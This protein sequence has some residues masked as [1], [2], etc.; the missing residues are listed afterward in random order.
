MELYGEI[1]EIKNLIRKAE[2][3]AELLYR[4]NHYMGFISLKKFFDE[5]MKNYNMLIKVSEKLQIQEG[6]IQEICQLFMQ[7]QKQEDAI[8]L[9]DL[10][11]SQWIPW[12]YQIQEYILT[13][14]VSIENVGDQSYEEEIY[15]N[16]KERLSN[17]RPLLWEKLQ[18]ELLSEE[19]VYSY[20]VEP[21]SIGSPTIAVCMGEERFYL[22][23]NKNPYKEAELWA[24]EYY[25]KKVSSYV[26]FGFAFGYHIEALLEKSKNIHIKVLEFDSKLLDVALHHREL[27]SILCDDRVEMIL[28][29]N[30]SVLMKHI[31]SNGEYFFIHAPSLRRLPKSVYK[32]ML[33]EYFMNISTMKSQGKLLD[34]NFYWN[35]RS[36]EQVQNVD[37]LRGKFEKQSVILVAGGP[38]LDHT[39]EWLREHKEKY[40]V[41]AVGT[42]IKKL[43]NRHI[44]PDYVIITDPQERTY[45]QIADVDLKDIPLLYMSTVNDKI[46]QRYTGAKYMILQKGYEPAEELA[47]KYHY[48]MYETGGSVSTTAID[49]CIRLGCAKLVCLGLDLA[50]T[51]HKT[52]ASDT[53]DAAD[54]QREGLEQVKSVKGEWIETAKNFNVYRHW[55][56]RRIRNIENVKIVNISNGAC[57]EGMENYPCEDIEDI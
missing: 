38:S 2:V 19:Q 56:E 16:N 49:V 12:L 47:N 17:S 26:I 1:E 13:E 27:T 14:M 33:E 25:D 34:E 7:T 36:L 3:C 40:L 48:Q 35:T 30:I 10:L 54:V 41:L 45:E 55:I 18:S 42:V 39:C 22:H 9:A 51:Y 53:M 32:E 37:E 15:H 4:Q 50:Y 11:E 57:I 8:F 28:D 5:F 44:I 6:A 21:T 24:D 23:S 31:P 52:H 20:E 29:S 46:A 43:L